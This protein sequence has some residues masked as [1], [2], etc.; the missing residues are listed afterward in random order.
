MTRSDQVGLEGSPEG[1]VDGF[2]DGALR[3]WA[4]FPGSPDVQAIVEVMADSVVVASFTAT[5]LRDD[6]RAAG[7]RG[8]HCGFTISL[9]D[10]ALV[11]ATVEIFVRAADGARAWIGS[12]SIGA[13]ARGAG[14]QA[15]MPV[16]IIGQGIVGYLDVCGGG[17]V[18]GW[19]TRTG[20][21]SESVRLAFFEK[22]RLVLEADAHR[23]RN[24]LA[25]MRQ[26]NGGCG[27]EERIPEIFCDG[28]LHEWDIRD[29]DT[30][31]S[32]LERPINVVLHPWVP[33][34]NGKSAKSLAIQAIQREK[35][36]QPL[37][38][39][40]IVNFYNMK[41][42]AARTLTSLSRQYQK[43][44]GDLAYEVLCID[45][46]SDP[47]LEED[48]IRGFGPEFKLVRPER[49]HPS[50]CGVI[51]ELARSARGEYVAIM[52]D[53]AHV[54][55]PGV[56]REAFAAIDAD[57][58]SV[59]A[60]RN[61]FVG[62]DQRWLSEVGYTREQED[63]LF[64][65][66]HWPADGYQLFHVGAPIGEHVD[67]WLAG[68]IESNFLVLPTDFYCEIGGLDEAFDEPGA[69][70]ANLDLF[71]RA[72]LSL[73]DGVVG[74]VG[75]ATFH[76]FHGGTTTNVSDDE[77]DSRVRAYS[78][79]YMRIRGED[80]LG[81][82]PAQIKL[83]GVI[84]D[85]IAM[86]TRDH[87]LLPL[88]LGVTGRVRQGIPDLHFDDG[89]RVYLQSA[90]AE[91]G[92]HQ[93]TAWLGR[94]VGVAPADLLSIQGIIFQ[95]RPDHVVTTSSD[96]GLLGFL[97]SMLDATG[98]HDARITCISSPG[99]D[100]PFDPSRVRVLVGDP[101]DEAI[102]AKAATEV[103]DAESTLVLYQPDSGNAALVTSRLH[104]Y[105]RLV[106]YRSYLIF[107]G[108]VF[109]QPWLGY[110]S[111]WYLAA[112]RAFVADSPF[113]IDESW[114]RQ[115]V[116]TCP[117]GYLRRVDG[118]TSSLAYDPGLD[119]FDEFARIR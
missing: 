44:I 115:W 15:L 13:P 12:A 41:R 23:W 118:R 66:I 99:L 98:L 46:G 63:I 58:G 71:R 53:G 50:P 54:L 9:N 8:G 93:A 32:L 33:R 1:N 31:R 97:L 39:S 96:L 30:G 105:S 22:G 104:A 76:Q 119:N 19:V 11:G 28:L 87:A 113:V 77:K 107:L 100:H 6:L 34:D 56:L 14:S 117:S 92:L 20:D 67:P 102:L 68:M 75:E 112:I 51:N 95:V 2:T 64:E 81:L 42:E 69:G 114:T 38:L 111:N 29:A 10:P 62:G 7:K 21:S 5:E 85:K 82:E 27:F 84:R 18:R 3:G 108:S 52:I 45:N 103:A 61:W 17:M 109:G 40:V 25:N 65:R 59:V 91:S 37:R 47:P 60:L 35:V 83:R 72:G 106:S 78:N 86:G 116:T 73:A 16:A 80:F 74:L 88:K 26:G 43:G 94:K 49:A 48:W 70:F 101:G 79:K 57:P 55:T 4:W 89:A 24:D 90:Y 110:S 36:E